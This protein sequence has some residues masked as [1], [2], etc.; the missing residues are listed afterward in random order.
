MFLIAL[1]P[2]PVINI[3]LP[4][5]GAT[6]QATAGSTPQQD[7]DVGDGAETS[8]TALSPIVPDAAREH[9]TSASHTSA[10]Q[11]A[12][13]FAAMHRAIAA[14]QTPPRQPGPAQ[15]RPAAVVRGKS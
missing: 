15:V 9:S 4:S 13:D 14:Q 8:T 6:W 5:A 11:A 2:P 1:N 12:L 10:L 3:W 7:V